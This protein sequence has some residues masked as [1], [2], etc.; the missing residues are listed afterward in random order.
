MRGGVV[1]IVVGMQWRCAGD[2]SN[3]R[4]GLAGGKAGATHTA[5]ACSKQ[6][7]AEFIFRATT[8]FRATTTTSSTPHAAAFFAGVR[9]GD[10]V[11]E[12]DGLPAE[13]LTLDETTT[14]LRGPV[15]SNV[16]LVVAPAG[17]AAQPPR[18]LDLERRQLPQPALRAAQLPLPDG[19]FV[20]YV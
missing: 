18:V 20:Q 1:V 3:R 19:R 13:S 9:K 11:L 8:R 5:S 6:G 7:V 4:Q 2:F 14:L 17:P 10:R 12:I 15:G 16:S